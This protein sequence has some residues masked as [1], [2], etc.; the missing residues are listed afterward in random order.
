MPLVLQAADFKL[1]FPVDC[2]LG[3]DCIIQNYVD[4]DPG[5]G[6]KDHQCGFLSYDGHKGTDIRIRDYRAMADGV[7]VLA[8]ADGVVLGIRNDMEDR[9]PDT[10]YEAYLK[11]YS[12]KECGNGVVLVHEKGFET[13]YCHLKKGSVAV[14]KGDRL[15]QG[16]VLGTIGL[17]GKTQFPHLHISVRWGKE[18]VDP[19]KGVCNDTATYLWKDEIGYTDTHLLKFGFA[20]GPQTLDSIEQGLAP[21]VGAD[22]PALVF[23]ANVVGIKKGDTQEVIIRKPDGSFLVSNSQTIEKSKVNWLSYVG[24]KRP[25]GGWPRGVYTAVFSVERDGAPILEH[26]TSLRI[27]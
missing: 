1:A 6:W 7:A 20:D 27:D 25:Q 23:W 14:K 2:T 3:Q 8:A 17:S 15:G 10:T 12:G 22:S 18:V 13:Q 24:K 21:Q 4:L 26:E 11:K 19:F 9:G 16:D 5:A